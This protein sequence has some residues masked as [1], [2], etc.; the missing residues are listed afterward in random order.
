[1][2]LTQAIV[3]G[4]HLFQSHRHDEDAAFGDVLGDL[5]RPANLSLDK[6]S[7]VHGPR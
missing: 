4:V 5:D 1:M 2:Q 3:P 7:L 6:A